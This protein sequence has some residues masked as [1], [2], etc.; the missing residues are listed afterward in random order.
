MDA[1]RFVTREEAL[2][3]NHEGR[4]ARNENELERLDDARLNAH[5]RAA[6]AEARFADL[7]KRNEGLQA[8]VE[9][10]QMAD[11]AERAALLQCPGAEIRRLL[12]PAH[13]PR[14]RRR[15]PSP[16][17]D[18]APV[19]ALALTPHEEHVATLARLNRDRNASNEALCVQH[20]PNSCTL[21]ILGSLYIPHSARQGRR[22][23]RQSALQLIS[24]TATSKSERRPVPTVTRLI[25]EVLM[26]GHTRR[27]I[28]GVN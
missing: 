20:R 15:E 5:E 28:Y 23:A 27:M 8:F 4:I 14:K 10:L 16:F 12:A 17:D 6:A 1:D 11:A 22:R 25:T 7:S 13:P 2:I 24:R 26:A 9:K 21:A 3:S 18:A 19:P